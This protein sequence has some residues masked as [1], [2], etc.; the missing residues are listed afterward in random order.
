MIVESEPCDVELELTIHEMYETLVEGQKIGEHGKDE[1]MHVLRIYKNVL[2]RIKR[3]NQ[4][5][6]KNNY[7]TIFHLL[8]N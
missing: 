2:M 4:N 7:L 6:I 1:L 5:Q 8:K 3:Q